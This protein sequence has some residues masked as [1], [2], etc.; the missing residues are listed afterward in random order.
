MHPSVEVKE[1]DTFEIQARAV[2][3][4]ANVAPVAPA[5]YKQLEEYNRGP[6]GQRLRF[7]VLAGEL[8]GPAEA[9]QKLGEL[10]DQMAAGQVQG[11]DAAD[12]D[13]A[14]ILDRLYRGYARRDSLDKAG[15]SAAAVLA[16]P[17]GPLAAAS[18]LSARSDGGPAAPDVT[19]EQRCQELK[20]RLG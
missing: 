15:A 12:R 18:A 11:A 2:V 9:L 1:F 6:A 13:T 8:K 20:D 14:D 10:W 17:D 5:L 4:W 7:V 19:A 3:G 16:G